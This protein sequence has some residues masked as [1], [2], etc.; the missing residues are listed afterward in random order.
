[1]VLDFL[2]HHSK[3]RIFGF[4]IM[5]SQSVYTFKNISEPA[6]DSL[7]RMSENVFCLVN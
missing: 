7:F 5:S 6:I 1:M 2:V 4:D 3:A